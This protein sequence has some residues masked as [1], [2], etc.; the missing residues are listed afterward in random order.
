MTIFLVMYALAKTWHTEFARTM[1]ATA[2]KITNPR[3][4]PHIVAG[5]SLL[6]N[7]AIM[8]L[9]TALTLCA[10][11]FQNECCNILYSYIK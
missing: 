4:S 9:R 8:R 6:G 10:T 3:A 1:N 2:E 11:T 7:V 5:I